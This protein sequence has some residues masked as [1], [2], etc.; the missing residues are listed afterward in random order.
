MNAIHEESHDHFSLN[1]VLLAEILEH[2]RP[3]GHNEE[4]SRLN[5]GFGFVYYGLVRAIRPRH[6]L[7]IGSGFGFSVICLA[8]GMKDNGMGTLTFVD[9]SY[10]LVKD[11]PLQTLGGRGTWSEPEMVEQRFR[12]FGVNGIVT[13]YRKRSDEFFPEYGRLGLPPI[14]MAFIDGNHSFKS[15]VYDFKQVLHQSHKNTYI[16]LHDS[17]IKVREMIRHSGVKRWIRT[18]KKHDK[19]FELV[20]FPLASGVALVRVLEPK[21]WID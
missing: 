3:F 4:K 2:A 10:S 12:Q 13:H 20:N 5:L 8:L 7:V 1:S 19:A 18:L 17:N 9:P 15:V 14:D 21:T 16:L 11:G 6:A